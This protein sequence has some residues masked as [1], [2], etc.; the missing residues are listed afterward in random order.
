[1][2]WIIPVLALVAI[3][4]AIAFYIHK[5]NLFPE[6]V[7]F[8][9]PFLAIKSKRVGF[10]DRFEPY[11]TFFRIYGTLGVIMVIVV[12]VLITIMLFISLKYTLSLKPEPTGIYEP[13]NILLIPG[14]NNYVPS[15]FA[16]WFAFVLTIA[17]HEMGHA[18][19]CRVEQIKVKSV[20]VL[21]AVIPIGFFVEPDEEELDRR[22]GMPKM[23]MFGA[24]ITNNI[25]IGV[26]C[27]GLMVA[28]IGMAVPTKE[29]VIQGVYQ[30]YSA[31]Q[32]GIPV[33]SV[34][35]TVNGI[36]VSS[37]DQVS[38]I[39]NATKPGDQVTL[40]IEK[41]GIVSSYTL[42]LSAWPAEYNRTGG[43]M[44]VYYFQPE[45]LTSDPLSLISPIGLLHL[46]VT[47]FD[48]SASGQYFHIL[49]FDSPLTG[50]YQVP[51]DQYWGVIH[52]LFWC[53]WIN[54]NVGIFNAIPM[55]PLDGGYILK[56]GVERTFE[57]KGWER[58]APHVVA[59]VS[60]VLFVMLISLIMLPYLM[61]M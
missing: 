48:T 25:V 16:V 19:L 57:R 7:T 29:P 17:I 53:G 26:I 20:G 23:R 10:F 49:A 1:M 30:N 52:L 39:L 28:A 12:S 18:I 36:S 11:K 37:R 33:D 40:G 31:A 14:I 45:A 6:H 15:T 41:D 56:E 60:Y 54:I 38:T 24:G 59:S 43:F 32:A 5:K 42:T 46:L 34:V 22:K 8:Y 61:H 4:A 3:Y 21:I 55:V 47:P 27:F 58:Y 2:H 51:F 35:K 44:G 50:S 9:G 13:Q